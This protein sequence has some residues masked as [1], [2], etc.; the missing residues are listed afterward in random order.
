MLVLL[1][2][3]T[4]KLLASWCGPYAVTRRVSPVNYEVEMADRRRKKR[5]FHI[6]MLRQWH[7]PSAVSLLAEK[8]VVPEDETMEDEVLL[9]DCGKEPDKTPIISSNL[10]TGERE[11]ME[12]LLH[13]FRDVLQNQPGKTHVA[14]YSIRMKSST[15]IK[16]MLL[17]TRSG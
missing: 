9:W 5:I 8:V 1:P 16:H 15:Q 11:Q 2:T 3:S 12:D 17:N 6:N 10:S 4:N 13:Q 14:E 7:P